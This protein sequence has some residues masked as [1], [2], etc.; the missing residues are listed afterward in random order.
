[1]LWDS[2]GNEERKSKQ[3]ADGFDEINAHARMGVRCSRTGIQTVGLSMRPRQTDRQT[4]GRTVYT[5][6]AIPYSF[7]RW[8]DMLVL[9]SIL[10]KLSHSLLHH[11][12][13]I[14]A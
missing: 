10:Q 14:S 2:F 13:V 8:G 3:M 12:S 1:M 9:S 5:T 4:D 7:Y 6:A 11:S